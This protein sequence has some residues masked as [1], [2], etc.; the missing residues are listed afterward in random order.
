MLV[1]AQDDEVLGQ[2]AQ[3]H[4]RQ[5]ARVEKRRRE[6]A[7]RRCVD[8]VG[9]DREEAE[10]GGERLDVD[11]VARAGNRA[12]AERQRV[13]F[14]ARAAPADRSRAAAA[15]RAP[16]ESARRAPAAPGGSACTPA[17]AHRRRPAPDAQ[18]ADHA[19][20]RL[21]QQR[22][23][24]AAGTAGDR[25]TPARFA[26]GPVCSRLPASPSRSTSSRSTKLCTSS[27]APSTNAGSARPRSR[28]A[29]SA[30]SI[31]RGFVVAEARR[32]SRSAL[33]QARLPVT[34]SSNRRRSKLNDEPHSKRRRIR[35]RVESARP[36]RRHQPFAIGNDRRL[37]AR[38]PA[39][40]GARRSNTRP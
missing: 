30:A 10:I 27:S 25:A 19:C 32:P 22:E 15:P 4:H 11:G 6:V 1:A 40:Y 21:L 20:D 7:I 9:D 28:I 24:G 18:R 2:P 8:A 33:A 3:V 14:L 26:S 36:E 31:G 38:R 23:S 34:S 37:P 17:S 39:R 29:R 12:G 35:G 5:R 13:G 16:G